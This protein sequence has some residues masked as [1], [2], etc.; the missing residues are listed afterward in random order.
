MPLFGGVAIHSPSKV[1]VRS[2]RTL[3]VAA[4]RL[5]VS[6]Q[7]LAGLA[8][9]SLNSR[10][11]AAY[12]LYLD[13]GGFNYTGSW[14]NRTPGNV[15]AFSTDDDLTT[16]SA[17]DIT[18]LREAWAAVAQKYTAFNVNVTTVDPAIAAGQSGTDL[19]R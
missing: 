18:A 7:A 1:K 11:G 13:F 10:P 2:L 15:P 12:T 3:G 9:P 14:A 17:G 5:V 16:F 4:L 8:V 6:G 19:A